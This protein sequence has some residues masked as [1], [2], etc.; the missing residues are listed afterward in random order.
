MQKL[1][2]ELSLAKED[3]L[4]VSKDLEG[5]EDSHKIEIDKFSKL[6]AD[7]ANANSQIEEMTS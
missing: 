7:S 5:I 6:F 3:K 4:S 1:E 2:A